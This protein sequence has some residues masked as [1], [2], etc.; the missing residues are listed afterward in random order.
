MQYENERLESVRKLLVVLSS[1]I[2]SRLVHCLGYDSSSRRDLYLDNSQEYESDGVGIEN[3][4]LD[5]YT[6]HLQ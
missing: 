1:R 3:P 6:L 4:T 2:H 5:R